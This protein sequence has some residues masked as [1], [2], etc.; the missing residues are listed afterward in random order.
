MRSLARAERKGVPA[1]QLHENHIHSVSGGGEGRGREQP[2]TPHRD[3]RLRHSLGV[4]TASQ[5]NEG[6]AD[7][8]STD[9]HKESM[10]CSTPPPAFL[11]KALLQMPANHRIIER[12]GLEG[13]FSVFL[14]KMLCSRTGG[15]LTLRV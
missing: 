9:L 14:W 6:G 13:T 2:A 10:T 3:K 15:L 11:T 7:V 1:F 5:Q 8:S 12:F 4:K